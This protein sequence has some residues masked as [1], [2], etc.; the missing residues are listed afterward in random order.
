MCDTPLSH[1]VSHILWMEVALKK[2][3]S[4]YHNLDLN[5]I[6][7]LTINRFLI[8]L[9]FT[10][11]YSLEKVITVLFFF[12][13]LK[14][15]CFTEFCW[16]LLSTNMNHHSPPFWNSLHLPPHSTS[17]GCFRAPVWVPWVTE[18]IPTGYIFKNMDC[19]K[20]LRVFLSQGPC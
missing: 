5:G 3:M 2:I 10:Y 8:L 19:F 4:G 15:N 20:N 12:F 14:D 11:L 6:S 1:R 9:L 17:L 18:Q 16:F 7:Y 13:E